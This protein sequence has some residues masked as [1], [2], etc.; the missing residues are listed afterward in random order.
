MGAPIGD[1]IMIF[2]RVIRPV[3]G[4]R[5]DLRISRGLAEQFG[6]HG[7]VA[8]IATGDLDGPDLQRLLID[9]PSRQI[10]S[11]SPAGAVDVD[12]APQAA[13]RTTRC[14]AA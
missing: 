12:L 3:C 4:D 10:A 13:F 5:A 9:A 2:A 8:G 6:Q 7:R 11:Q 14:P 1:G